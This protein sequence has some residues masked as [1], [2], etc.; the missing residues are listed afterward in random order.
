M[1]IAVKVAV[2]NRG[3]KKYIAQDGF[4]NVPE[5]ELEYFDGFIKKE[6]EKVVKKQEKITKTTKKS[7]K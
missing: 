5:S 2:V 3:G 4:I 7:T 6:A 1:K